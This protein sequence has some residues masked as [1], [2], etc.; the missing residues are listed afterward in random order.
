MF[1]SWPPK[2]RCFGSVHLRPYRSC[3]RAVHSR[4]RGWRRTGKQSALQALVFGEKQIRR[5]DQR[6]TA[7]HKRTPRQAK[8]R[9]R[10]K[11]SAHTCKWS[12]SAL[13]DHRTQKDPCGLAVRN[14]LN[15]WVKVHF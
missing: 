13:L 9:A 5:S 2:G 15:F 3:L 11:Q 6:R 10:A 12:L 1:L 7:E 4:E 14:S 8:K